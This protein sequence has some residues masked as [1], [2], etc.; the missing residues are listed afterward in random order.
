MSQLELI[1]ENNKVES[2]TVCIHQE[3]TETAVP[4][5]S[6]ADELLKLKQLLDMGVLT[7]EE[8]QQQKQKLLNK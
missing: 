7:D 8:F 5:G 3:Q 1:A 2:E 6:V 4:S